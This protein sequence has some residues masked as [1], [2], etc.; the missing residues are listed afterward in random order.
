MSGGMV[1]GKPVWRGAD[2]LHDRREFGEIVRTKAGLR[3]H[4]AAFAQ[5]FRIALEPFLSCDPVGDCREQV[6]RFG[7]NRLYP[8]A[9]KCF[10]TAQEFLKPCFVNTR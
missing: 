1:T 3:N 7:R 6:F 5:G 8:S 9:V 2:T 10:G 4:L